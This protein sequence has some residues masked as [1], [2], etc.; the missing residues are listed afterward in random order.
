M[1]FRSYCIHVAVLPS[2]AI[3]LCPQA[4]ILAVCFSPHTQYLSR[5]PSSVH[6]ACLTVFHSSNE[7]ICV[8]LSEV[9]LSFCAA[10]EPQ[11][12]SPKKQQSAQTEKVN[13]NRNFFIRL[14]LK[15]YFRKAYLLNSFNK[16][17][18]NTSAL[19]RCV[20][21]GADNRG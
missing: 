20:V 9:L 11:P 12:L 10:C 3:K 15:I 7:W 17:K 1:L 21:S 18:N 4:A 13:P 19:C 8:S 6:V 2:C 16:S 5:S 14:S